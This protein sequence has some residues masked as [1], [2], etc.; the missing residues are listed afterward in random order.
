MIPYLS[1]YRRAFAYFTI[2]CP[3]LYRLP[4][5]GDFPYGRNTGL[6]RFAQILYGRLDL[7][8]YTGSTTSADLEPATKSLDCLPFWLEPISTFGSFR[9]NDAYGDLLLLVILPL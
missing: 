3:H 5:R 2:S 4:S 9:P 7:T 8:S 6:A 1:H